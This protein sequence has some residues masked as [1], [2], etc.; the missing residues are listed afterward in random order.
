MDVLNTSQCFIGSIDTDDN[1]G[2]IVNITVIDKLT[3]KPWTITIPV[4]ILTTP[5]HPCFIVRDGGSEYVVRSR[6]ALPVGF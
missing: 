4:T 6:I 5:Q 1:Q 2:L 3:Q